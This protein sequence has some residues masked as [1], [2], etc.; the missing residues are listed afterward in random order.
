MKACIEAVGLV[1]PM[2][3]ARC[4]RGTHGCSRSEI[5]RKIRARC[6]RGTHPT[7]S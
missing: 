5:R 4:V 2:S 6:V 3:R 7:F 1:T